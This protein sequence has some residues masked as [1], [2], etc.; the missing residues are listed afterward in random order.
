MCSL[1]TPA[2]MNAFLPQQLEEGAQ[3]SLLCKGRLLC[4]RS[5]LSS[6]VPHNPPLTSVQVE[7]RSPLA[8][9]QDTSEGPPT[10]RT[11]MG[12]AEGFGGPFNFSLAQTCFLLPIPQMSTPKLSL[13][14]V[15]HG[16]L[17]PKNRLSGEPY[18]WS[19]LNQNEAQGWLLARLTHTQFSRDSSLDLSMR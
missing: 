11:P 18:P 10:S 17:F 6:E 9:T 12:L 14:N 4:S 16:Y 8:A 19:S 15:L 3:P 13:I 1:D 2:G 7:R 5:H